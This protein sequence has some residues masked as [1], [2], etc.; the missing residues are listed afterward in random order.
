MKT[1][2]SV[3]MLATLAGCATARPIKGP[4][5]HTAYFVKCGAAMIDRC[6][7]KAAEVCPNGYTFADKNQAGGAAVI[8]VGSGFMVARGP[9]SL[10]IE[11][12]DQ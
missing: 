12:K 9:N 8:P 1:I 5:G 11:C 4:S 2:V 6:Y 7:E 3:L 10:L